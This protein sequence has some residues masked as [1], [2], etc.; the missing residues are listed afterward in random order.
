MTAKKTNSKTT[1][2]IFKTVVFTVLTLYVL[3]LFSLMYLTLTT[4]F[5]SLFDLMN[6]KVGLPKEWI[7][8]N[9]VDAFEMFN[10][11]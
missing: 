2:I 6:N 5:K 8:K 11:V 4:S 1:N 7:F 3:I 9:Y 10:M